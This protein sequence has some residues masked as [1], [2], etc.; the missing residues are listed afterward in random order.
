MIFGNG[1]NTPKRVLKFLEDN[2]EEGGRYELKYSLNATNGNGHIV[3][4]ARNADGELRIYDP[5]S[6]DIY[7][8]ASLRNHVKTFVLKGTVGG[9]K[10]EWPVQLLRVDNLDLNKLVVEEVV[11]GAK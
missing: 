1:A 6:G 9:M 3:C 5:Q 8:G 11:E 7:E 2:I 10:V 4:I